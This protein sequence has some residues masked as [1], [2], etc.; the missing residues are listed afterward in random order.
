MTI[1]T[2]SLASLF[3]AVALSGAARLN[4]G[5]LALSF[6]WIIG[7]YLAG[8][9]V[10]SVLAGFP[11]SLATMLFGVTLLFGQAQQNGTLSALAARAIGL[12]H[13]HPGLTPIIF[14]LLALV[15]A[16]LGPGNIAAVALLAPLA[17]SVA[18]KTG[19]SAFLMTMMLANGA[20]AGAFSPFAPT[21]AIANGLIAGLG[22]TMNPWTEVY[23]P[24]LLAQT[25]VAAAG[26]VLFGGLRLWRRPAAS[27]LPAEP[28]APALPF[29][30]AQR[31]TLAAILV[32]VVGVVGFDADVGLL[33]V[34]L[35]ALLPLLGAAH[36]E[37]ALKGVPWDTIVMVCGVSILIALL[38]VTGGMEVF[39]SLLATI[40]TREN[41]TGVVALAAGGLSVYSSSSGVVMPT[42]IAAVPGLIAKL[43]GG[44][45]AALISAINV[46]S[47][48]VDVSP[49]STLGALCIAS[50]ASHENHDRLFRHLL[51]YGIAMTA[52][53]ALVCYVCFGL[54]W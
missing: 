17:M 13:G 30:T 39:T 32:L 16:T 31:I 7:Y 6:A 14:F 11:L 24:S 35:A 21:G 4:A 8:M 19:V 38:N 34:T 46:G 1:A 52:V 48:L 47:H 27:S 26:Y 25:A 12:T 44:D 54:F 37:E 9:S 51:L 49:L 53:G 10:S 45:A 3:V 28:D 20:N 50:A 42:F 33:A 15:L 5:I 18:G 2:L 22:L 36:H 23:L 40:S 29:T 41:V 43:G